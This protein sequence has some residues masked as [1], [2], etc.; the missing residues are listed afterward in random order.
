M[1]ITFE[2]ENDIIIYALENIIDYARK[3]QYIF[4]A[5]SVWWIASVV[6]LTDRL[7]TH[8]HNLPIRT[9][10]YQAPIR[11]IEQ[12]SL[13]QEAETTTQDLQV[14]SEADKG[15][16]DLQSDRAERI[17]K[18][19]KEFLGNSKKQRKEFGKETDPLTRM[20]SGKVPIKP[21]TK[22]QQNRLRAILRDSL[23]ALLREQ[24]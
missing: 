5:Q 17:I 14:D 19:T 21:L 9:E 24:K 13:E 12:L 10:A 23:G 2:S 16:S 11:E 8:I 1:T 3:N 4:V 15:I 7:A 22:K 18:E 20:R 6:G